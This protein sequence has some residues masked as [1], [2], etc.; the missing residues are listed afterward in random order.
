MA[1]DAPKI[2]VTGANG[3]LGSEVVRQLLSLAPASNIGVSVRD[4]DRARSFAERGVRVRFGD[5]DHPASLDAAFAGAQRVLVISTLADNDTRFAQQRN[6]IDAA[7]R[8]GGQHVYYTSIPQRRGSPFAATPGHVETEA[9]LA[10]CGVAHTIV[11]NG[12]Y[13]ENLPMFLG[14]APATG[15]L[16]LPP[17]GPVAWVSRADLAEG[18]A[19][20]MLGG[21]HAGE[22]LLLTGPEALD[23]EAIAAIASNILGRRITRRVIDGPAWAQAMI[24]RGAPAPVARLLQTG[25]ISRA[26]GE[27]AQVDPTLGEIVGRPLRTVREVLPA[28]LAKA[29]QPAS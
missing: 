18:I 19:R 6:A 25:W 11:R 16:A 9:Y 5:F 13:M 1:N 2:V 27:L 28:L 7:R 20:L 22:S 12:N 10:E 29:V 26:A 17:D 23:F 14:P 8:V 15:D 24:A 3:G 21:G 4:P